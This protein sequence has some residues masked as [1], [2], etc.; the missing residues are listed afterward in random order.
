MDTNL[1]TDFESAIGAVADAYFVA[2]FLT[3]FVVCAVVA[4][5]ALFLSR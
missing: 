3:G 4:G 1:L 2:G 5:F